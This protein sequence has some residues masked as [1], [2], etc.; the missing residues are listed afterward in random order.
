MRAIRQRATRVIPIISSET[1]YKRVYL[2]YAGT[3]I[4]RDNNVQNYTSHPYDIYLFERSAFVVF[5]PHY[6]TGYFWR[7]LVY[8][9]CTVR[10]RFVRVALYGPSL[11]GTTR[12]ATRCRNRAR[13][14]MFTFHKK[15]SRGYSGG[16]HNRR[17][18]EWIGTD[19]SLCTERH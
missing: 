3:A 6:F 1:T 13:E 18:T 11:R 15:I 16:D 10:R 2:P 7:H 19:A 4:E 9:P 8:T 14:S 12:D 5:S 17:R